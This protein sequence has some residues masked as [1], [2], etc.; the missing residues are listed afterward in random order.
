[1][2]MTLALKYWRV[3]AALLGVALGVWAYLHWR[4]TQRE[5]GRDEVR[6][7]WQAATD[8][9]KNRV[10]ELEE[11][12]RIKA[13]EHAVK[14]AENA[15]TIAT[16]T[17]KLRAAGRLRDPYATARC[18]VAQGPASTASGAADGTETAGLLSEQFSEMLREW[19]R[20]ADEINNAYASAREALGVCIALHQ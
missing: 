1:M 9:A 11:A 17:D 4:D 10:E 3:L 5:I 14:D 6:A 13:A 2:P 8:D 7:E 12:A 20:E 18:P 16:L 15:K 19:A